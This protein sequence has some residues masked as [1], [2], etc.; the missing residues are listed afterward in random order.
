MANP[1]TK[2]AS[3]RNSMLL[4]QQPPAVPSSS[5]SNGPNCWVIFY[6]V[7]KKSSGDNLNEGFLLPLQKLIG[8]AWKALAKDPS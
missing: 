2:T 8:R 4:S 7:I 1:V 5:P 3:A 6:Q